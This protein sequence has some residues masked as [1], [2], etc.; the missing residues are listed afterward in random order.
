MMTLALL[1]EDTSSGP[2]IHVSSQ[3]VAKPVQSAVIQHT[4]KGVRWGATKWVGEHSAL[5][6]PHAKVSRVKY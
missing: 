5:V 4:A 6:K 2:S 1:P 3:P